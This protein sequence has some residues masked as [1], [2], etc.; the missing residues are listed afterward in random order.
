MKNQNAK[1]RVRNPFRVEK[2]NELYEVMGELNSW[3]EEWG[4]DTNGRIYFHYR[5]GVT[6]RYSRREFIKL[7]RTPSNVFF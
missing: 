6:D 2:A 4:I 1:I 5:S 3:A 7:A